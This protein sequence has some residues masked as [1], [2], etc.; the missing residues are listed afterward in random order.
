MNTAMGIKEGSDKHYYSALAWAKGENAACSQSNDTFKHLGVRAERGHTCICCVFLAAVLLYSH[1]CVPYLCRDFHIFFYGCLS[2]S[3]SFCGATVSEKKPFSHP[4]DSI[5]VLC[6]SWIGFHFIFLGV[7]MGRVFKKTWQWCRYTECTLSQCTQITGNEQK[8][9]W[10][11]P[12]IDV[13]S[14]KSSQKK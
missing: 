13:A 8:C 14:Q 2:E 7:P 10:K 5:T 11:S 9:I 3:G 1:R 6:T 4:V 12:W